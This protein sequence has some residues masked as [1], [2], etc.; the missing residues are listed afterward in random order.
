MGRGTDETASKKKGQKSS[1]LRRKVD[2]KERKN[3]SLKTP[4]LD[5]REKDNGYTMK[6]LNDLTDIDHES[7]LESLKKQEEEVKEALLVFARNP[8]RFLT[9]EDRIRY[10]EQYEENSKEIVARIYQEDGEDAVDFLLREINQEDNVGHITKSLNAEILAYKRS[11]E[12]ALEDLEHDIAFYEKQRAEEERKTL[13]KEALLKTQA[14]NDKGELLRKFTQSL[15]VEQLEAIEEILAEG[16]AFKNGLA[17]AI[18]GDNM[19]L[20]SFEERDNL[21]ILVLGA[22]FTESKTEKTTRAPF[23]YFILNQEKLLYGSLEEVSYNHDRR[24][25]LRQKIR[26]QEGNKA[27]VRKTQDLL[28]KTIAAK[29]A[30]ILNDIA[31]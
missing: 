11:L 13:Y 25:S 28:D 17:A 21:S 16:A 7:D 31:S 24:D 19:H 23:A 9:E 6:E 26:G 15:K 22:S 10:K 18:R 29:T 2:G 20:V 4:L 27:I 12:F 3:P 8:E 5:E 1:L 30:K 14:K